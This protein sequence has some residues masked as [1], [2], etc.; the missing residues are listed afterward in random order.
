MRSEKRILYLNAV[1]GMCESFGISHAFW[2][3][4]VGGFPQLFCGG[5]SEGLNMTGNPAPR[6]DLC[7]RCA[8]IV[9]T[10]EMSVQAL[11][12]CCCGG[13]TRGRQWWNRDTD[14]GICER[15]VQDC[16]DRG[17]SEQQIRDYYGVRGVHYDLGFSLEMTEGRG[18]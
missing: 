15:C 18:W 1:D 2:P 17:E 8:A 5:S 14:Y 6:T 9:K 7:K 12:C 16:R 3:P 10:L 11:E 13:G 4:Y